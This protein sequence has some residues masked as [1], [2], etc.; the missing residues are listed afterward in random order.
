MKILCISDTHGLHRNIVIPTDIDIAIFA[1]DAG[2]TR[3]PYMNERGII[4]FI[5]W[6]GSLKHIKHKIWIAG[7]HCTSIEAG[8]VNAKLRSQD[9]GLIYL[10]H[11]SCEVE[12]FKIFGSPYTPSFG[13]GWAYNVP[14]GGLHSYWDEIP[15]DTEILITHGPPY[16]IGDFV[17]YNGGEFVGCHELLD[18]VSTKLPNLKLNVFGHIHYSHGTV[19]KNNITFV[20]ASVVNEGY[21]LVNE[22]IIIDLD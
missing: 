12:G 20:N 19:H 6:Y 1:G 13:S 8:L 2:T 7:N 17:P 14:R 11:D 18:V 22:P 9:N 10:E 15:L 5:D 3:N 16:G 4:D 21:E